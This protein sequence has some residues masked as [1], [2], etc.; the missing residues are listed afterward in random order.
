MIAYLKFTAGTNKGSTKQGDVFNSP[1]S[2]GNFR[3]GERIPFDSDYTSSRVT[4]TQNVTGGS[5]T[6]IGLSWAPVVPGT[7]EITAVDGTKYIDLG[8]GNIYSVPAG[9]QISR[10]VSICGDN[11]S[12]TITVNVP[13]G[14]TPEKKGTV[15]Y[16]AQDASTVGVTFDAALTDGDYELAYSYNNV[17]IPQNDLPLL[18][19]EMDGIA[20]TAKARRIAI[21]DKLFA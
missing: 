4:S 9:T 5:T 1:F 20:L 21:Y 10:S 6:F 2:L 11:K 13:Q 15:V 16:E 18:N 3:D 12:P 17:Y 19:A 14:V 7:V 8:D